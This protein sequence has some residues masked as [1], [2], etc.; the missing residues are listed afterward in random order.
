MNK[1]QIILLVIVILSIYFLLNSKFKVQQFINIAPTSMFE[2][3]L[4]SKKIHIS[5]DY[6]KMSMMSPKG[7]YIAS[8]FIG[9]VA[10]I[11][12]LISINLINMWYVQYNLAEQSVNWLPLEATVTEKGRQ[13]GTSRSN[14]SSSSMYYSDN[15]YYA[16]Q[17]KGKE[18]KGQKLSY[19]NGW[20]TSNA[21]TE[22]DLLKSVPQVG[23][24][25]TIYFNEETGQSVMFPGR[26][27][28]KYLALIITVP[29]FIAG[30]VISYFSLYVFIIGMSIRQ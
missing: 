3:L 8:G 19:D 28:T 21:S 27:N 16:F 7:L 24:K 23:E 29:F 17:Y 20:S 13:G 22:G 15:V 18:L 2:T 30:V 9:L 6:E 4:K 14:N 1:Y 11:L 5:N 26:Q 25:T 12:L 10:F